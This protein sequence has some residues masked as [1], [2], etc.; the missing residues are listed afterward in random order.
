MEP[1][2]L[3]AHAGGNFDS[4]TLTNSLQ[5]LNQSYCEGFRY[6][7]LDFLITFDSV[8]VLSHDWEYGRV[9]QNVPPRKKPPTFKEMKS[10]T[11]GL[12]LLDLERLS[13]WIKKHTD[14]YIITDVK[15]HNI[16]MLQL[17]K[18][19]F[20]RLQKNIIPQI[21]TLGE[22]EQ[23]SGLG[24]TSIILT[25]Y[26][27]KI[28]DEEIL[29]FCKTHDL[30]GLT[31]SKERGSAEFLQQ[32]SVLPVPVFIHTINNPDEYKRLRASGVYG[33]YTD[34]LRPDELPDMQKP[35]DA[36]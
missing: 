28:P 12:K 21:Y 19:K 36:R 15:Y 29:A 20:L 7:E 18:N 25:L 11:K 16:R 3:I 22:Y 32:C 34:F 5:A 17:I 13:R 27:L 8:V 2:R 9:L 30:F 23:V 14:V 10:G 31:I 26:K 24:Y 6:I 33:V 35:V 1:P 4:L